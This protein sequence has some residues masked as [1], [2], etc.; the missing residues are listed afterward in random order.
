MKR[1]VYTPPTEWELADEW[2]SIHAD[3]IYF[4]RD[5]E[6]VFYCLNEKGK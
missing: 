3:R 4:W 2:C 1:K 6:Q 5:E